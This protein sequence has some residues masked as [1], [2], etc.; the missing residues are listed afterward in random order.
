VAL[1]LEAGRFLF[2]QRRGGGRRAA[3]KA[4]LWRCGVCEDRTDSAVWFAFSIFF[5]FFFFFFFFFL[6]LSSSSLCGSAV[7]AAL[8]EEE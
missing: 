3:E 1:R 2:T 6:L 5:S 8:R 7:I 4:G